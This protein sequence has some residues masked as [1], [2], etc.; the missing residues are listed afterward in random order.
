M[1]M[2]AVLVAVGFVVLAIHSRI[3]HLVRALTA[4]QTFLECGLG[5]VSEGV[6]LKR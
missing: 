3:G 6:F 5:R 1:L 4:I 2:N